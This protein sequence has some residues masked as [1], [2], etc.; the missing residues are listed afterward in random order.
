MPLLIDANRHAGEDLETTLRHMQEAGIDRSVL[1]AVE[2]PDYEK[3]NRRIAEISKQH[4][5][6]FIA[7]AR[8][9][10]VKEQNFAALLRTECETLGFQGLVLTRQPTRAQMEVVAALKIPVLYSNEVIAELHMAAQEFP[11][12]P[13]LVA[14]LGDA[15]RG[16]AVQYE[17]IGIA[18]RYPNVYLTTAALELHEYLEIAAKEL[19]PGKLIFA[20]DGPER[21]SRVEL[22]RVRL[23]KLPPAGEAMVLGGNLERLLPAAR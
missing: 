21:D 20:S 16:W 10:P 22:H 5:G 7:F 12:V 14:G 11:Q 6:K 9:H 17:V 3:A 4:P 8:H 15:P 23:L 13:F 19:G 2:T 18:R 1:S